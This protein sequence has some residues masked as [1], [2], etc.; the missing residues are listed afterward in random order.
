VFRLFVIGIP[1]LIALGVEEANFE[2]PPF[3]QALAGGYIL[4]E[5]IPCGGSERVRSGCVWTGDHCAAEGVP[6]EDKIN[7]TLRVSR[8]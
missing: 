5:M 1:V 2:G 7:A 8:A 4:F 6:T 3:L